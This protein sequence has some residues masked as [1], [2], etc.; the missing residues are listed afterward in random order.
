[1]VREVIA[2]ATGS[3][4]WERLAEMKRDFVSEEVEIDPSRSAAA[5]TAAQHVPVETPRIVKV[6]DIVGEMEVAA[7]AQV[8][9]LNGLDGIRNVWA[10]S[11]GGVGYRVVTRLNWVLA[12][13][14]DAY[15][16]LKA[17]RNS[18]RRTNT[19]HHAYLRFYR[20]RH[21]VIHNKQTAYAAILKP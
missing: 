8:S 18:A 10:S 6:A 7:H 2:D 5:L 20:S 17:F 14:L 11:V 15:P 3:R 9:E 21:Q 1:M 19:L 12:R 13:I 4:S 16:F